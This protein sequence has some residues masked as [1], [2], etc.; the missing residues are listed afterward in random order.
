MLNTGNGPI[1]FCT[2]VLPFNRTNVVPTC[3]VGAH[4]GNASSPVPFASSGAVHF[5]ATVGFAVNPAGRSTST[6]L[7]ASTGHT[8]PINAFGFVTVLKSI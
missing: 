4:D 8:G 7:V 6:S 2:P 1:T 3:D 5:V